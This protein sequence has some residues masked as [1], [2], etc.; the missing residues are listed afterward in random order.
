MESN[1][2]RK[3]I[4]LEKLIP[5]TTLIAALIAILLQFFSNFELTIFENLVLALLGLIGFDAFIERMGVLEKILTGVEENNRVGP[6]VRV[7]QELLKEKSFKEF[8]NKS[9]EIFIF[10]GSLAGLFNNE[11]EAIEQWLASNEVAKMKIILV[12]PQLVLEGK[13]T[14]QSLFR[15]LDWEEHRAR[16]YYA[17]ETEK[18]IQILKSLQRVYPNR[19]Q[20]R[21]TKE[22]PSV[23]I[24]MVDNR[25]ARIS[26][27][28]YQNDPTKRP[29]FEISTDDHD[30]WHSIFEKLYC[31]QIWE[32][33]K[34]ID[35][36]F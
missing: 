22:T 14:V 17:Q 15:Y 10:G 34:D 32:K 30:A 7:E 23:T 28:L 36:E 18:S 24:L 26:I 16:E 29:A 20:I 35:S 6:E 1:W 33:S 9:K 21:L 8:I 19:I 2:W 12:N 5:L 13:I 27:N 25:K 3:W 11:F 4:K 31:K